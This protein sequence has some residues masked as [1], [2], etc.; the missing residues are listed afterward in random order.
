M[1]EAQK[2]TLL[3]VDDEPLKR[4]T[5]EI[6]L[7]EAGFN[8]LQATDGTAALNHLRSQ[9]V[10]VVITDL[11]MPEMDGLQLLDEIKSISPQTSVLVMTA[12]GSVDSAV[13]A[14][15]HGA[16]DYLTKPFPTATLV[17]KLNRLLGREQPGDN[18]FTGHIPEAGSNNGN[19]SEEPLQEGVFR[20]TET[21]AGVERSLIDAALRRAAGN[22]AKAAQFLG[23]PR[24]T[25]RDK[26]AKYGFVTENG[27]ASDN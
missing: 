15:K 21:I 12:F 17:E 8:V 2:A 13:Q 10:D 27:S 24:T 22:Q 23:I 14:I 5:L 18:G 1:S 26:M 19:G 16:H 7:I 20:L 9:P 6:D 25:L 3:V 4:I 11:R